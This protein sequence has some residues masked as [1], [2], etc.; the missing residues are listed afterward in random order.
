M[1]ENELRQRDSGY[2]NQ[3]VNEFYTRF[4]LKIDI[5]PQDI[6]LLLD[7]DTT[8]FKKLSLEVRELLILEGVQVLPRPPTE[9]NHQ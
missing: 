5:I 4:L 3:L 6:V 9:A 1:S 8:F 7:I 2:S